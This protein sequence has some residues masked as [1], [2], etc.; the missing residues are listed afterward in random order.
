MI[1]NARSGN[2]LPFSSINYGTC[3]SPEGRLVIKALLDVSIEGLG[4][5][6]RTSIFPCGIFQYSK[7]INGLPGTPNYDLYQLALKSTSLRLYPNYC[8]ID[9]SNQRSW[10]ENDTKMKQNIIDS[11]SEEDYN[12]LIERIENNPELSNILSIEVINE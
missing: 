6:G 4:K 11:L 5:H 7:E 12:K 1:T 3:T 8:N 10:K 9:W 2:Q